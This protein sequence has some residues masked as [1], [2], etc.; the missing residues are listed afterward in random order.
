MTE[1]EVWVDNIHG[2]DVLTFDDFVDAVAE[3]YKWSKDV[4][5]DVVIEIVDR[6]IGY[7]FSKGNLVYDCHKG[8]VLYAE[9]KIAKPC[10][11][12]QEFEERYAEQIKQYKEIMEAN[13]QWNT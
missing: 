3:A 6:K 12:L 11:S 4:E 9:T 13:K 8:D 10:K 2:S 1:Y 7:K 5:N